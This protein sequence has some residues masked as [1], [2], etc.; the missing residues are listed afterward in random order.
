MDDPAVGRGARL[1][2]YMRPR[3]ALLLAAVVWWPLWCERGSGAC[4]RGERSAWLPLARRVADEA[5][6]GRTDLVFNTPDPVFESEWRFGTY[7]LSALGLG[8]VLHRYPDQRAALLPALHRC[9]EVLL[10]PELRRSH[11]KAWGVDP[12]D[13]LETGRGQAGYLGY[14]DLALG[15]YR[16]LVPENEFNPLHDRLNAAL[17]RRLQASPTG[18]IETYPRQTFPVDNA[19][20]IGGL[21]LYDR[22]TG[23]DHAALIRGWV[24]NCRRRYVEPSSGLLYQ[25][26][27]AD[28]GLP[29]DE[30]RGSGTSLGLYFLAF[31]DEGFARELYAALRRQAIRRPC[32][33]GAVREYTHTV[34]LG[35]QVDSGPVVCGFGLTPTGFSL[36]G[37]RLCGDEA[38]YRA[39]YRS[40]N[41]LACP[42]DR[43]GR[44][45]YVAGGAL[46]DA[47]LLA[48]FT[49]DAGVCRG[50]RR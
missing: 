43:R 25:Q 14:L 8:Q 5:L 6:A 30:A 27:R 9:L 36:A 35:G 41:L 1:G 21:G 34:W 4:W 46:G 39:L 37:A 13:S 32:G 49:A 17:A 33:F 29:V 47:L 48:M 23:A 31:A 38:S 15:M 16:S 10:Q 45:E 3:L 20:V 12:L 42:L 26:V 7:Q 28:S 2:R 18:L 11:T 19:A 22:V 24:D 50:V 40:M 44:R